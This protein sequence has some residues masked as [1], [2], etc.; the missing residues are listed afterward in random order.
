VEV[1]VLSSALVEDKDRFDSL[2]D[3]LA[4]HGHDLAGGRVRVAAGK[5]GI[6]LGFPEKPQV[7]VSW[8]AL[9]GIALVRTLARRRRRRR[10][11]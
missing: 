11:V 5:S 6:A 1:Q 3:L 7:H 4:S 8:G 9:A 10:A 2:D